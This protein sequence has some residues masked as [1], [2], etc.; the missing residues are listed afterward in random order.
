M[1]PFF[2]GLIFH[3]DVILNIFLVF[4]I[5]CLASSFVY[6][7]NDI[8]D[9]KQDKL[10]PKKSLRPLAHRDIKVVTGAIISLVC[11][12]LS[13][14]LSILF[15]NI[16]IIGTVCAYILLNI[17]YSGIAKKI[18]V[19]D[20]VTLAIG[21]V[22]RVLAG[23]FASTNTASQ[24]LMV[25]VFILSVFLALGKRW[26]DVFL[27]EEQG[28][29]TTIRQSLG[30]YTKNF[31]LSLL[32]FFATIN[33]ICYIIYSIDT[34]KNSYYFDTYFFTTSF[35]VVVGNMR[36]LQLIFVSNNSYSPTQA[37]F[38]DKIIRYSIIFWV[39]HISIFY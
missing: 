12:I 3:K 26:H 6:I 16:Y 32:T 5:F 36:Y 22:I 21:F 29:S 23:S 37:L 2:G 18:A 27:L 7:L 4:I 8:L 30:G 35:W 10:H 15:E 1:P 19:I 33:T 34:H 38:Y 24:W 25:M 11:L 31:L 9:L 28:L 17:F 20:V 14:T 39:L 13:L